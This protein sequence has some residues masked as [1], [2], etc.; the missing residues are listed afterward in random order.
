MKEK[1]PIALASGVKVKNS[2]VPDDTISVLSARAVGFKA[3]NDA[4]KSK[5]E[6]CRGGVTNK[7][8]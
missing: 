3:S 2:V 1:N 5:S 8:C 6:E 4:M 7:I